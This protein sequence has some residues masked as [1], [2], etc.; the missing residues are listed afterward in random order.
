MTE[1][2]AYQKVAENI[3]S[4]SSRPMR[5]RKGISL[6]EL[7]TIEEQNVEVT[8]SDIL[9]AKFVDPI[10]LA[11]YRIFPGLEFAVGFGE[12]RLC[13][14]GSKGRPDYSWE[15]NGDLKE[16]IDAWFKGKNV[17]PMEFCLADYH[18]RELS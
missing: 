2:N 7:A 8:E 15:I 13:Y 6:D 16:W 11:L 10:R 17:R 4:I 1:Q 18:V 12:I 3:E 5:K 9:G 14:Y